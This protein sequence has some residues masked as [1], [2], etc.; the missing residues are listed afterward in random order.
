MPTYDYKCS[1]CEHATTQILKI[2]E[3]KDPESAPCSECGECTVTMQI[4]APT[5]GYS[6]PGS[7][8]TTDSFNDRLKEIKKSIPKQHQGRINSVIR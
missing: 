8:K 1:S 7:L 5:I 6:N 3:R 2:S 4:C